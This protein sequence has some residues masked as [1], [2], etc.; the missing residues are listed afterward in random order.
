MKYTEIIDKYLDGKMT[1]QEEAAFEAQAK[2]DRDLAKEIELHQLAIVGI[3]YIQET[4]YQETKVRVEALVRE[5]EAE[6]STHLVVEESNNDVV[7]NEP[8]PPPPVIPIWIRRKLLPIAAMLLL[9]PTIY[10]IAVSYSNPLKETSVALIKHYEGTT[11]GEDNPDKPEKTV[12]L[13]AIDLF[14]QGKYKEAIPVFDEIISENV[15]DKPSAQILKADALYRQGKK[16]EALHVLKSIKKEDDSTLYENVQK[17][18]K[19]ME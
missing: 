3:Q 14:K 2:T 10:F 17:I 1:S 13:D 7:R 9:I 19:K 18:I 16:A 15:A 6:Q 4:R 5:V 11:Q 12:L 8:K